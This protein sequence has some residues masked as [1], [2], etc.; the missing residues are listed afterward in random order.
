MAARRIGATLAAATLCMAFQGPACGAEPMLSWQDAINVATLR[1]YNTRLVVVSTALLGITSGVVGAFLLLRK[2]SLM[3]DAL[4]HATLPGVGLAFA[5]AVAAGGDGK[6]LPVLLGG[7]AFT[8]VLGVLTM[9]AIRNTTR[10]RDDVAMGLVLSVYFGVGVAILG[11]VQDMPQASAAGLENFIYGKTASMV[12]SDF[13]PIAAAAAAVALVCGALFK[14]FTILCFDQEYAAAQGW[15]A[16]QLDVLLL[17]LVTAVTVIGL[18]SVGLILIIAFLIT[19][20]AAARFWSDNLWAMTLLSAGIGGASGW[21]GASFSALLPRM[22]AGAV[23]VLVAA[24]LFL[25]SMLFAPARGV[26][27]RWLR[28]RRLRKKVNRQHLL[29]AAYEILEA[30]TKEDEVGRPMANMPFDHSE[31]QAKRS[32][33]H[34]ELNA[35]VRTER[36]RGHIEPLDAGRLRLTEA[37]FGEA[38]RITRNH[39]L[40]EIYLV[41]HA[42]IAPSHVDR[43]A[44]MVEHVLEADLVRRL[45][46]ELRE[47]GEWI[48]VPASLHAIPYPHAETGGAR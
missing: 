10:L 15:P 18:Q 27:P 9:L 40:W 46:N 36:A 47:R 26:I 30:G 48:P 44:D 4:S 41:T 31:L 43:D 2:R 11:M 28:H 16:L 32:W 20:A 12:L 45:E 7:G 14:E 13:V 21:I 42:D 33:S 34:R 38:A 37:G 25:A 19:P 8:G 3:G 35:I 1:N 6:S 29:R 24:A 39:R 22:P 5:V 23:I 17:G